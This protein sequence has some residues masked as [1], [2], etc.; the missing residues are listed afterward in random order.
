MG[1]LLDQ[2]GGRQQYQLVDRIEQFLTEAIAHIEP[3]VQLAVFDGKLGLADIDVA[4]RQ[5]VR[6]GV[7]KCRRV[8]RPDVHDRIG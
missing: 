3:V 1:E 2:Q 7:Q 5:R 6:E 4:H 8:V